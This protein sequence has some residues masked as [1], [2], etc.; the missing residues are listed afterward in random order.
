MNYG[1]CCVMGFVRQTVGFSLFLALAACATAPA[2]RGDLT[3]FTSSLRVCPGHVS[4]APTMNSRR[5]VE[6]YS[7]FTQVSGVTLARAPT[8]GCVSSGYGPRRGGAGRYHYGL[9]IF[10]RSP[11]PIYA[12]GDGV[13]EDVKSMRGYGRTITIRHNDRV[14]TR[15]AHLS[16]YEQGLRPGD[17]IATGTLIGY[18]GDS[19]NATAIHL[20]YEIIVGGQARNPLTVGR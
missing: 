8:S 11:T 10:T 12:G 15:Y 13:V 4:N 1:E 17:R 9:D 2:P 3:N 6:N 20:H 14:K 16:A 19:G 18:T 7:P 5:L